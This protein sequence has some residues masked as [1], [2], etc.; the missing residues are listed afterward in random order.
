MTNILKLLRIFALFATALLAGAATCGQADREPRKADIRVELAKDNLRQ[1]ALEAAAQ[2]AERALVFDPERAEAHHVLGMV[3]Y[4][5]ALN[6]YRLLEIDDCLSGRDSELLRA[7]LD[8][9]LLAA[10]GHFARAVALD[11]EYAEVFFNRGT[12]AIHLEEYDRAIEFFVSALRVP[13]RLA[14][15]AL[16]RA[17]LGWAYFHRENYPMAAK[18]L[19]QALQ[20]APTMCVAKYRLGRVYFARREWKKALEFFEGV[21]ADQACPVQE[22]E[23]Y[24]LKTRRELRMDVADIGNCLRLAPASCVALQCRALGRQARPSAREGR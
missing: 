6:H 18:E 4:L 10:D 2:E 19:R 12:V 11:P 16:T 14:N 5:R 17:S 22:A 20:F 8:E 15:L 13:H 7:E 21:A 3:D 1:G 23:L 9:F 24:A